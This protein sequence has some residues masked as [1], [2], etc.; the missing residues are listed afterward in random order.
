[1]STPY[2]KEWSASFSSRFGDSLVEIGDSPLCGVGLVARSD[3]I[4]GPV[5]RVPFDLIMS[6]Q[7]GRCKAI[8]HAVAQIASQTAAVDLDHATLLLLIRERNLGAESKFHFYISTLPTM[9][10]LQASSLPLLL[11]DADLRVL[12]GTPLY[13]A[14][15]AR[16]QALR[17]TYAALSVP[18]ITSLL[19]SPVG[20]AWDDFL[21]AYS[22]F[23]SR[24]FPVT[25]LGGFAPTGTEVPALVP[26]AD[27]GNHSP[28]ASTAL[29][30]ES[31]H[32][33]ISL[34]GGA[35]SAGAE[36]FV[37]Y[38]Q[39]PNEALLLS[40]GF[41]LP[42]NAADAVSIR[43]TFLTHSGHKPSAFHPRS[44]EGRV[45]QLARVL[46]RPSRL[47]TQSL[48]GCTALYS[49]VIKGPAPEL[50]AA[51]RLQHLPP[52]A[53]F[54][55]VVSKPRSQASDAHQPH[56][57]I[58]L[59]PAA[60]G[61]WAEE[62]NSLGCD[63]RAVEIAALEEHIAA[64]LRRSKQLPVLSSAAA[65][66]FPSF[67]TYIDEQRRLLRE[68]VELTQIHL[69]RLIASLSNI[70]VQPAMSVLV[71]AQGG[72]LGRAAFAVVADSSLVPEELS[73]AF[74]APEGVI[75]LAVTLLHVSAIPA[76]PSTPR[77]AAASDVR[78]LLKSAEEAGISIARFSTPQQLGALQGTPLA[79]R[80]IE[81]LDSA[82]AAYPVVT[83]RPAYG[84]DP[85]LFS[86]ATFVTCISL[87]LRL[88]H[89]V[90]FPHL[91]N[92]P[93]AVLLPQNPVTPA[94]EPT[95]ADDNP[96]WQS[97]W[98]RLLSPVPLLL[99]STAPD[100]LKGHT[101]PILFAADGAL[102]ASLPFPPEALD[103]VAQALVA[104]GTVDSDALLRFLIP[105]IPATSALV[106]PG[107]GPDGDDNADASCEVIHV[108]RA[109]SAPS[110][111]EPGFPRA[112]VSRIGTLG[113]DG[114]TLAD[115]TGL[116]A[117]PVDSCSGY[118]RRLV[119]L[120]QDLSHG[121]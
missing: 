71:D 29:G 104:S 114:E 58:L 43:M 5:I 12:R 28:E 36:F 84:A 99:I 69:R 73:E 100:P 111:P 56:S 52:H 22:C 63:V 31:G 85:A 64:A 95:P 65:D 60:S 57:D 1:M 105:G 23:W 90:A 103:L 77:C 117:L 67:V 59:L 18:S 75:A 33:V 50:L 25:L 83:A 94:D 19:A 35:V 76:S 4:P 108:F 41:A 24:C 118:V 55:L 49:S 44:D 39:K 2:R 116:S 87:A 40:Y 78:L 47:L 121:F 66:R 7:H 27:A 51:F 72:L 68:A 92:S 119:T 96:S 8:S 14:V 110:E 21:W 9:R 11:S 88:S 53:A 46:K 120:G 93:L 34:T 109:P 82:V 112:L 16:K 6:Y 91:S 86:L 26:L 70:P 32:F 107:P 61:P 102:E 97:L 106:G 42:R 74:P 79:S 101:A 89:P 37:N 113:L 10:D 13:D 80:V 30:C 17:V 38:G 15:L 20:L 115:A 62:H 81:L 54:A 98:L 45:A 48:R 3:I